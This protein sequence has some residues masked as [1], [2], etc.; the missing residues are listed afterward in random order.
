MAFHIVGCDVP[1]RLRNLLFHASHRLLVREPQ[2]IVWMLT[3]QRSGGKSGHTYPDGRDC[4]IR[5]WWTL[6]FTI[7]SRDVGCI[8]II[9]HGFKAFWNGNWV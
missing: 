8:K 7:C 9:D 2:D 4:A 5:S 1:T 6:N 3:F